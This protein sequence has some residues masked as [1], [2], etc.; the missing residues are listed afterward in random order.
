MKMGGGGGIAIIPCDAATG[1][2][3]WEVEGEHEGEREKNRGGRGGSGGGG[4]EEKRR[5]KTKV[6]RGV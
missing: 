5:V 2:K 3:G 6:V 1:G 4:R